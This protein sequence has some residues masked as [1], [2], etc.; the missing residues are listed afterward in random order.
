MNKNKLIVLA[1][2]A[3]L[4]LGG[5]QKAESKSTET[6][7]TGTEAQSSDGHATKSTVTLTEGKY[8]DEKLDESWDEKNAV[9]IEFLDTSINANGKGV[10]VKDS[11]ATITKAG[12]YVLS[13][14]LTDGQIVVDTDDKDS[15]RLVFNGVTLNSTGSA[16]VYAKNGDVIITL[17]ENTENTVTDGEEYVY[18]EGQDE[19]KAAIFAG[20]DLTF[21]G[22]GT[23]TVKGNYKNA[24]QCK[25]DLK[26]IT[27]TYQITA[28]DN[29]IVGKDS[30]SVKN[31]N[32]TIEAGGDGIK[33]T[34]IEETDKG[35]VI[36][37]KGSFNITAGGDG[38]QAETLLRVNDGTYVITAGGGS[39]ETI[40]G[41]GQQ[42]GP[43]GREQ[44]PEGGQMPDKGQMP[45]EGQMPDKGQKPD[46]DKMPD[47]ISQSGVEEEETLSTKAL[48]SYVDLI[49]AGGDFSINAYD[50]GLHS[51][52]N[53]T[54]D[55]GTLTMQCGDDGVHADKNLTINGGTVDIQ[56]S[57]EGLEGFKIEVNGGNIKV[58]TAD[59]GINAAEGLVN[60]GM[61]EEDQG[62]V[63]TVNGG[64]IYVNADGDGLDANGNIYI[65]GGSVT[66]DGPENGGNGTLDFATECQVTGGTLLGAGSTGMA[67]NPS[68]T[69]TQPVIIWTLPAAQSAGSKVEVSDADGN[70]IA[71]FTAQKSSQWYCISTPELKKGETYTLKTGNNTQNIS[72]ENTI[73]EIK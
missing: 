49:V 70:I 13:G 22:T 33:S 3:V 11:T 29:G 12:T 71:E 42:A 55:G 57:Y 63:L 35:Y 40:Q 6:N 9:E 24:I 44:I 4:A 51:N 61:A 20:D 67:Q 60:G 69:S 5:C 56:K 19:P 59:D 23:L 31:G 38:V 62:A 15:V 28:V 27:G 72:L 25:N 39:P 66:V 34:N 52:Q 46:R 47:D 7:T 58:K 53:V 36:L 45:E 32:F 2:C 30:V 17:A 26:F 68:D 50:D 16:P 1:V 14:Q 73:T 18:D 21:N 54:I 48:K 8:S 41:S 37:E 10:E 64:D 65:A 43:G